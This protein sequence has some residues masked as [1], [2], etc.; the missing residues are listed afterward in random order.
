MF[1]EISY[2]IRRECNCCVRLNTCV[3]PIWQCHSFTKH[4]CNVCR[5]LL[6]P[7]TLKVGYNGHNHPTR[8]TD[9]CSLWHFRQ[10]VRRHRYMWSGREGCSRRVRY[11]SWNHQKNTGS[12]NST[13]VMP[14]GELL[15]IA[16][17]VLMKGR[18]NFP[19]HSITTVTSPISGCCSSRLWSPH[20]LH[21]LSV[22]VTRW[23]QAALE[24]KTV[25]NQSHVQ[26]QARC[27]C[28]LRNFVWREIFK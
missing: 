1:P 5:Q 2:R 10:R 26:L 16:T 20:G 9:V 3:C 21:C 18:H 6:E 17:S 12:T 24:Q 25:Y 4:G 19:A 7:N 14:H 8:D 27:P 28:K 22:Q 15:S 13:T 11:I 23:I